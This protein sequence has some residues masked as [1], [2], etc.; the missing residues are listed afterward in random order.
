MVQIFDLSNI[1]FINISKVDGMQNDIFQ[2]TN[3]ESSIRKYTLDIIAIKTQVKSTEI[4]YQV[5]RNST[6]VT[7]IQ[8]GNLIYIIAGKEFIQFQLLEAIIDEIML[9]FQNFYGDLVNDY[10]E[11]LNDLFTG[12]SEIIIDII[13]NINSKIKYVKINC[14]ACKKMI[15]ICIKN[16]LVTEASLY[17][18]NIVYIHNGHG[19]LLYIDKN[20]MVRGAEIVKIS[21]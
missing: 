4:F 20:F 14:K 19:I 6:K 8:K 15:N 11:E 16:T 2:W 18:V 1:E 12:F 7:F 3:I 17:P 10:T 21:G 9:N 5:K 13:Q